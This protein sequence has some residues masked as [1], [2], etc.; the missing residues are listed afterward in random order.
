MKQLLLPVRLPDDVGKKPVRPAAVSQ[1]LADS[2]AALKL[3]G[4]ESPNEKD[5]DELSCL[6]CLFVDVHLSVHVLEGVQWAPVVAQ[7]EGGLG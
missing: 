2:L 6:Y 3:L 7:A 4:P 1:D 5:F